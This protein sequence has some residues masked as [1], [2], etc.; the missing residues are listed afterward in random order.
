MF[1][2]VPRPALV[3]SPSAP[4]AAGKPDP[5]DLRQLSDLLAKPAV[6][7]WLRSQSDG[8]A[9][10]EP[11]ATQMASATQAVGQRLDAA[12]T[13]LR[14]LAAGVPDLPVQL[15]VI[16]ETLAG[17]IRAH[18]ILGLVGPLVLFVMLGSLVEQLFWRATA[19]LRRQMIARPIDTV[20]HRLA[21]AGWRTL[22]GV[23][24]IAAFAAGSLGAFLALDWPQLLQEIVLSYLIVF[25]AVRLTSVA[26][27][28]MLAP[29]AERFRLLPMSTVTARYWFVWSA[30]L[31]GSSTSARTLSG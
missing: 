20:E 1:L 21:A 15:G 26:G 3:Q 23:G 22:Y 27:R 19:G 16:R 12:R 18:R 11:S 10:A 17:E 13:Q 31:V 4:V 2:L 28:I 9:P 7:N 30:V 6:R 25:L 24:V 14:V 5:A 8:P 29:G